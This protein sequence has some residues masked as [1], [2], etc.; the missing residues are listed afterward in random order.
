MVTMS[1]NAKERSA[2]KRVEWV[3]LAKGLTILLVVIMHATGHV[4]MGMG[5]DGWMH[6]IIAFAAPFRMPV[7]FAVSGLFAAKAIS[8]DWDTFLNGK[9]VHFAYFYL[10]WMTIQFIFKTPFFIQ[11]FGIEGTL[12]YW[13]ASFVQPF[14]LLWFIYLL[15]VYF[16]VL[17]LTKS[18]PMLA[19]FAVAI[20]VK[21]YAAQ[22]GIG[23]V[24][25]FSKYYVFFL[26]G[27][28]GRDIWFQLAETAQ[29]NKLSAILGLVVWAAANGAIVYFGYDDVALVSVVMGAVGFMAVIDFMA[30]LPK[31]GLAQV[32]RFCGERSL[33]IYLGFFLPMGIARLV[34]PKLFDFGPGLTAFL[35]SMAAIVGAIVMY[36][37]VMRLKVGT[38]LYVRP[39]WAKLPDRKA[40]IVPA[41]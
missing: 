41:E 37:I 19:Q 30:I 28:F 38:F 20:A 32:L 5:E 11:D 1:I 17:R 7:F 3:D 36:E 16:V 2:R 10:L 21:I 9:F 15:P 6:P 31:R 39:R 33:P 25:F 13:L 34:I 23:V 14:G 4:E 12:F 18:V 27:H 24:D 22:T 35:V 8:K 40:A 26:I 29:Q